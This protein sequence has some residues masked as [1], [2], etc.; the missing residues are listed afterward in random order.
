[1]YFFSGNNAQLSAVNTDTGKADIDNVR[2]DGVYG[3]Y[4]SPIGAAGRV[5]LTGRDGG[6]LVI[7][8][9]PALEVLARNKLDDGFDASPAAVGRELFLRGRESLYCLAESEKK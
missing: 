9:G 2:L 3:V 5:Y 6:M 8:D 7:K 4:A 1:M